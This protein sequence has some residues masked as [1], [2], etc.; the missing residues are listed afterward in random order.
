MEKR[1]TEPFESE[2]E[3]I[4]RQRRC[5]NRAL[6]N[7]QQAKIKTRSDIEQAFQEYS[8]DCAGWERQLYHFA[9]F[10]GYDWDEVTGD[11]SLEDAIDDEV[12]ARHEPLTVNNQ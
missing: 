10:L 8:I 11:R 2:A 9:D 12:T 7:L 6:R 5:F 1:A 4:K 3:T